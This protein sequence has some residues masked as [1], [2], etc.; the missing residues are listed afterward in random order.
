MAAC[1]PRDD[2]LVDDR[3]VAFSKT[4]RQRAAAAASPFR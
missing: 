3:L 2:D 4:A 1:A